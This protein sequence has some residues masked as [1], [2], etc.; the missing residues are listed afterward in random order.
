MS[1]GWNHLSM[2][3]GDKKVP[4]VPKYEPIRDDVIGKRFAP[5]TIRSCPEP[6]VIARFGVG[7]IA[8][9]SV[10]T[11]RKCKYRKEYKFHGGLGCTYGLENGVPPGT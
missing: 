6:H 8:N 9:V 11:C 5:C 2:G 10:H 1:L 7:G 3:M 4:Y